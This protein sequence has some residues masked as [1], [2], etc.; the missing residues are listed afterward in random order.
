MS[1]KLVKFQSA[2]VSSDPN[3]LLPILQLAKKSSKGFLGITIEDGTIKMFLNGYEL[4]KGDYVCLNEQSE[5]LFY[6]PAMSLKEELV[7]DET[8]L[9]DEENFDEDEDEDENEN[10][11]EDEDDDNEDEDEDE[12]EET[13]EKEE[14]INNIKEAF[15]SAKIV[16]SGSNYINFESMSPGM[17]QNLRTYTKDAD[18]VPDNI[19]NRIKMENEYND[20]TGTFT[21]NLIIQD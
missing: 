15:S 11:N 8:D 17:F 4:Q 18:L 7:E 14:V 13:S 16:D 20:E 19:R 12:D 9:E 5:T 1:P 6:I 3:L 21:V 10:E 2:V